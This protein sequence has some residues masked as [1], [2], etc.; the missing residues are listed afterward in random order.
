MIEATPEGSRI[1]GT[2]QLHTVVLVAT[3]V[4]GAMPTWLAFTM[5]RYSWKAGQWDPSI[6][7]IPAAGVVV[8]VVFRLAFVLERRRALRE[9]MRLVEGRPA[10]T[11]S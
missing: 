11:D 8:L 6:L 4:I 9:L 5:A 10:P 3:C 7:A 2:M 1:H